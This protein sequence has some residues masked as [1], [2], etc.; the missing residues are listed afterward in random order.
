MHIGTTVGLAAR[1][2]RSRSTTWSTRSATSPTSGSPTRGGR[3]TFGWDA[4]SAIAV[5]G[6]LV[7]ASASAPRWCPPARA[8]PSPSASQALTVQAAI[9]GRLTLG[10]GPSHA[11]IIEGAFGLAVRPTRPPTP[12]STC[13]PSSRCSAARRSTCAAS[14]SGSPGRSPSP[15]PAPPSCSAALGPTMLRIAGELTDGTI[16]TWTGVRTLSEHIVPR[17]GAAADRCRP[18]SA[19]VLVSVPVGVT[20]DPDGTRAGPPSASA[21]P[22]AC[23]ATGRCSIS[24]AWPRRPTSSSRATRRTVERE[25]RRLVD[26]GATELIPVPWAILHRSS[27]RWACWA[28]C[29]RS[30]S[31]R[32]G[33]SDRLPAIR[34][35]Q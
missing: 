6:G 25:L 2:A 1:P 28:R 24:R 31:G 3:R 33:L 17:I 20:D 12:G 5:A 35:E 4:L 30:R 19:A 15:V 9:G 23:R 22:T 32:P 7:P 11:P 27:A 34:R 14:S 18:P 8:I 29:R 13:R 26:A 10:V 16:A 21:P